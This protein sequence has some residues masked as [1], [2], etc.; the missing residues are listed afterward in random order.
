MDVAPTPDRLLHDLGDAPQH[1]AAGAVGGDRPHPKPTLVWLAQSLDQTHQYTWSSRTS[2]A[3]YRCTSAGTD[4]EE[5]LL[6]VYSKL[7]ADI[8]VTGSVAGLL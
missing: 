7:S 2:S 1:E 8:R 6:E 3:K 4:S 5:S